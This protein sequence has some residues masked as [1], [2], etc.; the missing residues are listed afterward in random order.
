MPIRIA[1]VCAAV[2]GMLP[3]SALA[4]KE[5]KFCADPENLP[6]SNARL[7]GF[8]N[9]I[10]A[11]IAEDLHATPRF[12]WM[13]QRRGFLRRTLQAGLCDVVMGATLGLPGVAVTRPYYRSTYVF[14][15]ASNRHLNL[16]GFDDPALRSLRIGLHVIG[17]G[18]ANT[19]PAAALGSRGLADNIVGYAMWSESSEDSGQPGRVID[20]VA[21][22]DIDTAIVW[23]PFAGY[24]AGLHAGQLT[25]SPI[26]GDSAM[27][28]T[29]FAFDIAIG[30]RQ[31]DDALKAAIDG[32]LSRRQED[33]QAI[34]HEYHLPLLA[35]D[36]LQTPALSS[37]ENDATPSDGRQPSRE[38]RH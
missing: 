13:L 38:S 26:E 31:G 17:A 37:Q 15:T 19:P 24:F 35:S 6:F 21:R 23:G 34:L 11:L 27:P 29:A 3:Q 7:E 1:F 8:E 33:I 16:R 28:T 25:I 9:R 22:G 14:V 30:V 2:F 12:Q 36:S 5:L 32:V 4:L 20:A 10:A 18:G